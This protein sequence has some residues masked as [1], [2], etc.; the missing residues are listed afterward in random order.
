MCTVSVCSTGVEP[1]A[2]HLEAQHKLLGDR[3][4]KAS[5]LAIADTALKLI[6]GFKLEV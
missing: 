2:S 5:Q 3:D 4:S 1:S 6:G